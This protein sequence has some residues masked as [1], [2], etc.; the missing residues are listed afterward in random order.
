MD[1]DELRRKL[2][3]FIKRSLGARSVRVE[4]LRLLTGGASRQTWSLDASIE[5][6]RG[7]A[8][9]VPLVLRSDPRRGPTFMQREVE[10]RLLKCAPSATFGICLSSS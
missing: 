9:T 10:Y 1:S 2:T 6:S 8:R 5:G 3:D 7:E 4:G